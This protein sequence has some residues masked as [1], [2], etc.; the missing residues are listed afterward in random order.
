[1]FYYLHR[2]C[3]N[4]KMQKT[5]EKYLGLHGNDEGLNTLINSRSLI[6]NN[7]LEAKEEVTVSM[8]FILKTSSL[9]AEKVQ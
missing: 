3:S 5:V 9:M 1:M 2:A 8:E 6:H 4:P 7:S